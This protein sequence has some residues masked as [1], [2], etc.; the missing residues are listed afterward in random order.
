MEF[1][2]VLPVLLVLTLGLID[3]G[4]AYVFGVAVQEAVRE[5]TRVAAAANYDNTVTQQA[6]LGR[7]MYSASPATSGCSI[8][9][10]TQSCNTGTWTVTVNVVGASGTT[11]TSLDSAR[12]AN[13]LVCANPCTD[14]AEATVT[15]AGSVALL[16]GVNTGIYGL[17]LPSI[18]VH[19]QSSMAIL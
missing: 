19:G 16:P 11:Y 2:I 15:I 14:P 3:L 9:T 18:S 4:R 10:G 5:A 6:V 1:A 8:A 13:D 7:L 12:T 17:T